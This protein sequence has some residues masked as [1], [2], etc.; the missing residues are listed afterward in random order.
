M[1]IALQFLLIAWVV[2]VL[3]GFLFF[4]EILIG[5]TQDFGWV[6][7]LSRWH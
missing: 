3:F 5:T 4:L 6:L 2:G 7:W 1:I